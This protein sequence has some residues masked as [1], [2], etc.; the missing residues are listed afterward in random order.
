MVPKE[1]MLFASKIE[2]RGAK[3][4]ILFG[5][6]YPKYVHAITSYILGTFTR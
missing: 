6:L 4:L 5:P 1:E 3:T 2:Q